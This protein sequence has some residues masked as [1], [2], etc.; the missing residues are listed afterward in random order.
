MT[1]NGEGFAFLNTR[2]YGD[3]LSGSGDMIEKWVCGLLLGEASGTLRPKRPPAS[4]QK[5]DI[6]SALQLDVALP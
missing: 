2:I 4:I 5:D 6:A 1:E 3:S